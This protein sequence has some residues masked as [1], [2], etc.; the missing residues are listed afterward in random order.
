MINNYEQIEAELFN[1]VGQEVYVTANPAGCILIS[2]SAKLQYEG[3]PQNPDDYLL[4][5]VTNKIRGQDLTFAFMPKDV[6][7]ICEDDKINDA[8]QTVGRAKSIRL[9]SPQQIEEEDILDNIN[10]DDIIEGLEGED[11]GSENL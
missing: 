7:T 10:F 3:D 11:D 1:L 6:D 8:G 5:K 9:K 4:F 2:M